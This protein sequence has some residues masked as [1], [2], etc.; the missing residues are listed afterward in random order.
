MPEE[1]DVVR[2]IQGAKSAL[3]SRQGSY[4]LELLKPLSVDGSGTAEVLEL[5]AMAHAMIGNQSLA[6]KFF[7][8]A[9][10][11]EPGRVTSHYNF[12]VFLTAIKE[13]HEASEENQAVLYL[14][15]THAGALV[16]QTKLQTLIRERDIV[17]E[18]GFETVGR[19][20]DPSKVSGR[21]SNLPCPKCG[22]SNFMTARMCKKCGSYIP[23]MPEIIPVE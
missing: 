2:R 5:A 6:S 3:Q 14:Q 23:E 8:Q 11:L 15:P 17:S 4:A 18:E 9:T 12:A 21:W 1:L 20:V 13:Y 22:G 19:G 10:I 7:R 16:L